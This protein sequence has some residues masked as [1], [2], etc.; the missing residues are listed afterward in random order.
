[1]NYKVQ[2]KIYY[3]RNYYLQHAVSLS[4]LTNY[5]FIYFRSLLYQYC[6][7]A[8]PQHYA[9]KLLFFYI[10]TKYMFNVFI[11]IRISKKNKIDQK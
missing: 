11:V 7:V 2:L 3:A 5:C 10:E 6:Y 1:M 4:I 8:K 9:V